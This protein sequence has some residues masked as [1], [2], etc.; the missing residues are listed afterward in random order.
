MQLKKEYFVVLVCTE[1]QTRNTQQTCD[2]EFEAGRHKSWKTQIM[3]SRSHI[4]LRSRHDK[5][6]L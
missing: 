6:L 5:T 4:K 1:L 2:A 3:G